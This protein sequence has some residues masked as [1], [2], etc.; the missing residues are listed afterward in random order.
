MTAEELLKSKN[1]PE[2]KLFFLFGEE[3]YLREKAC[4]H[5]VDLLT[6][7]Q[8]ELNLT[9]MGGKAPLSALKEAGEQFSFMGGGTTLLVQDWD[10]FASA[11]AAPA[12][13]EYL[14][15]ANPS[16]A[17]VFLERKTPDKRRAFYKFLMKNAVVVTAEAMTEARLLAWLRGYL[18][19]KGKLLEED[20]ARKLMEISGRDM[21][22]LKG[23]ADKL[24]VLPGPAVTC[25]MV[26]ENASRSSEYN[27]F[28]LHDHMLAGRVKE[29]LGLL[30]DVW[31]YE[32]SYIP[33]TSLLAGKWRLMY[34]AKS[35][36]L[37]GYSPRDAAQAVVE[38][39]KCHPFAAKK[40]VEECTRFKLE[41][42][43]EALACL[44]QYDLAQKSNEPD[45]GIETLL[46]RL[47][48]P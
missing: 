41:H 1:P 9:T 11:E 45:Q 22:A 8:K 26:E 13:T 16:T 37:S 14:Q 12:I 32:K 35:C 33:L 30:R 27:V 42:L 36:I 44:S 7:G 20:A 24:A 17:F 15:Q 39:E 25:A 6:G 23:E 2:G 40:A 18:K 29:A 34:M 21:F 48:C 47:Y 4:N 10:L 5:L 43:K 19:K 46:I 38:S 31:L 28:L 3:E